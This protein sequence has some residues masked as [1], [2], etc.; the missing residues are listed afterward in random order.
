MKKLIIA[1][2]FLCGLAN[3]PLPYETEVKIC[4]ENNKELGTA[5]RN[6]MGYLLK[7]LHES[8]KSNNMF[9]KH[10][11]ELY[12]DKNL[13]FPTFYISKKDLP[14][15][16]KDVEKIMKRMYVSNPHRQAIND[17]IA[18]F[19]YENCRANIVNS[20]IG[21]T[22]YFALQ[23]TLFMLYNRPAREEKQWASKVLA[24]SYLRSF[25][26]MDEEETK[27]QIQKIIR[28]FEIT[29]QHINN[30]PEY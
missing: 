4:L 7:K 10:A 5:F 6:E 20:F 14:N 12:C 28:T 21:D 25:C 3:A 11:I 27:G 2:L 16:Q 8:K 22:T 19:Y 23:A 1:S 29:R 17:W 30:I 24:I 18:S 9:I 13:P 15:V 26:N